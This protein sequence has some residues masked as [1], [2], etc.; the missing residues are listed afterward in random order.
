MILRFSQ[1]NALCFAPIFSL[2]V[3]FSTYADDG[4]GGLK[5]N[6]PTIGLVLSGGGARGTAHI[7]VLKQLE[8]LRIP[9]D[10]VTGT[11][12]GAVAGGLYAHGYSP[13]ELEKI[14]SETDWDDVF[15][16]KPPR[17]QLNPRRKLDH[18]NLPIKYEMGFKNGR[19]VIP[20]GLYQGQK[21]NL[22]LKSLTLTAPKH[23]DDLPIRFR[24]VA[25][26]IETGEAVVLDQGDLA[27]VMRASLSIPGVFAPVEWNGQLLVDG[28]YI[29]NL[30]VK[31]ARELGADVLIVVDLSGELRKRTELTTPLSILNQSIGIQIQR[32]TNEQLRALGSADVLI[33][34]DTGEFSSTDYKN[35]IKLI[36]VGVAATTSKSTILSRLSVS[37]AEYK[38]YIDTIRHKPKTP[39]YIDNIVIDDQSGLANDVIEAQISNQPGEI[40]DLTALETDIEKLYG[41]NIFKSVDYEIR[42][43]ED[44]TNLKIKTQE[45]DWG[46]R[47]LRFGLNMEGDFDDAPAVNVTASYNV[48]PVHSSGSEWRTE[49]QY[50]HDN[51]F[52]TEFYQ[53]LDKRMR[54][55]IKPWV[56]YSETNIEH[57][58]FDS[59][60]DDRIVASSKI[61]LSAGRLLDN[62]G[63]V[64]IGVNSQSGDS[65]ANIDD[66][67]IAGRDSNSGSWSINF[68]Y[69]QLDS[70]D[71]PNQGILANIDWIANKKDLGADFNQDRV[72][73]NA[74]WAGTI[75]KNSL[76]FWPSIAGITDT[77]TPS[78]SGY[79]IGGLFSLSGLK[80]YELIGRYAAVMRL[81]YMRDLSNGQSLLKIPFYIGASLESGNV[82]DDH[83]D[84]SLDSMLMAGSIFL[85]VETPIGPFYV[86]HGMSE[87]GRSQSYFILGRNF[88][89]F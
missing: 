86:A 47:Y 69:D 60:T 51:K 77:H 73:L 21:L 40:L 55:F 7:G 33:Q 54:Y 78:E 50:G 5:K 87:G 9:I 45:K 75:N 34:P 81:M 23:F 68:G 88:T 28:S 89:Y 36:D 3:A 2:L 43:E 18:Q 56:G 84:I 41:F 65:Q 35:S 17:I 58:N 61:G 66:L 11:S 59:E 27:T 26:D 4:I 44:K 83:N 29:N 72:R 63:T 30:P 46:P 37:E 48:I 1:L 31:L 76:I 20:T 62:W 70:I 16:D 6:R 57:F 22:L 10:I 14:L 80:K 79:A 15:S 53:P 12:M 39:P 67:S 32:N 38:T 74:I 49:A 19:L 42:Q 13:K 8:E 85:G 82:W 52:Y 71:F 25:A 24:A 64:S